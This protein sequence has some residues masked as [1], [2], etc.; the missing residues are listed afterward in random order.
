MSES[1]K[2]AEEAGSTR[3]PG[4]GLMVGP[5]FF[6]LAGWFLFGP[7]LEKIPVK[8]IVRVDRSAL[9]TAPRRKAMSEAK[10]RVNGFVRSC[11]ECH[12]LMDSS[13]RNPKRLIQHADVKLV[14]GPNTTC[15]TCHGKDRDVLTG[16]SK[17]PVPFGE[18]SHLCG[19]CHSSVFR[20]WSLGMH[21]RTN[22]YW[23]PSRGQRLRL[24]CVECHDPHAPRG[25]AMQPVVP[26][27][28]PNGLRT[29]KPGTGFHPEEHSRTPLRP[30]Y[31][32][33]HRSG[34]GEKRR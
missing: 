18:S 10:V 19:E 13:G 28:G 17:K 1:R 22:G 33:G 24:K 12:R 21:G 27:P 6:V 29:L 20:D 4:V 31:G 5:I 23:D 11:M 2:V 9:S 8:E 14:H 34:E 7:D 16:P 15:D 26:L 25:P 30:G 3:R 32:S